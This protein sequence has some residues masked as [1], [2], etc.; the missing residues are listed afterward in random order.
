MKVDSGLEIGLVQPIPDRNKQSARDE[1]PGM[2]GAED[3][4]M[5]MPRPQRFCLDR[6]AAGKSSN[7]SYCVGRPTLNLH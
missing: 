1:K 4:F 6:I 5:R 2:N 3:W 7:E